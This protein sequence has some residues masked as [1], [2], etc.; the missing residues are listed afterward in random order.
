MWRWI[1]LFLLRECHYKHSIL[2]KASNSI[3][4]LALY[5][6]LHVGAKLSPFDNK[7]IFTSLRFRLDK[8]ATFLITNLPLT[9]SLKVQ[10][11]YHLYFFLLQCFQN[12]LLLKF[13]FQSLSMHFCM[14][15]LNSLALIQNF[16]NYFHY[17][18]HWYLNGHTGFQNQEQFSF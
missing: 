9:C 2:S 16:Q 4:T 8:L 1:S 5:I 7:E 15:S 18:C 10:L 17:Y 11:D 12:S 3:L 13:H 6:L 14:N